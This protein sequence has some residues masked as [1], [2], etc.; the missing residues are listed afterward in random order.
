MFEKYRNSLKHVITLAEIQS[1]RK[2]SYLQT[3]LTTVNHFSRMSL[4]LCCCCGLIPKC[5][6]SALL[7]NLMGVQ[8]L[9]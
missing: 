1:V 2:A 3:L 4:S 5:E 7:P 8:T 9:W 6:G